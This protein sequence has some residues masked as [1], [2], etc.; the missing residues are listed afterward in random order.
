MEGCIKSPLIFCAEGGESM[1]TGAQLGGGQYHKKKSM[2]R[3]ILGQIWSRS[4]ARQIE[5][6][7]PAIAEVR[8]RFGS[9]NFVELWKGGD[10][11]NSGAQQTAYGKKVVEYGFRGHSVELKFW[12]IFQIYCATKIQRRREQIRIK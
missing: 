1:S 10:G 11:K 9:E 6:H 12:S 3:R 4:R 2:A 5:G 8:R 7:S